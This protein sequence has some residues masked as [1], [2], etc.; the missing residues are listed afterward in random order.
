[1]ES[2]DTLNISRSSDF[3]GTVASIVNVGD[4]GCIVRD[5]E[6]IIVFVS[7][8]F[9]FIP[10]RLVRTPGMSPQ[11]WK[12]SH[13]HN[14]SAY[15]PEWR[16]TPRCTYGTITGPKTLPCGTPDTTLNSLLQQPSTILCCDLFDRNCQ[17]RQHRTS[18][19]HTTE[20]MK[21]SQIFDPIRI[22]WLDL[23]ARVAC[24]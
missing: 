3:S 18:N 6:T 11:P 21:N 22:T 9:N 23:K 2:N 1:M 13:L 19:T 14:R 5:L 10:H 24:D 16:T 20:L 15:S 8:A 12:R 17:Y 4:W 7:L